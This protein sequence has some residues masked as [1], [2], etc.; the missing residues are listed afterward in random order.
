MHPT[1]KIIKTALFVLCM[2]SLSACSLQATQTLQPVEPTQNIDETLNAVRTEAV[3]TNEAQIA[4]QAT[5]TPLPPTAT[6]VDTATTVPTETLIPSATAV[7]LTNTPANTPTRVFSGTVYPTFTPGNTSTPK[8]WGCVVT[9][10]TPNDY[11][12]YANNTDFDATWTLKNTGANSWGSTDVD[13][14]F[15]SGASMHQ[16]DVYNLG[17]TI[18]MGQ[19][20]TITVDMVSPSSAGT[21]RENWKLN[22]GSQTLCTMYVVIIVP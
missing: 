16:K 9:A 15:V 17:K 13:Y 12:H 4:A 11:T 14:S 20:V 7:P 5:N 1:P 6:L 18:S 2:I 8:P 19:S 10:G 22:R 3:Q 21:Y